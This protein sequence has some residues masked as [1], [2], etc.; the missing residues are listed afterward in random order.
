MNE[1]INNLKQP[2]RGY[3]ITST[4]LTFLLFFCACN[5]DQSCVY[6]NSSLKYLSVGQTSISNAG[7]KFRHGML[8]FDTHE[9]MEET[10]EN[11]DALWEA[12]EHEFMEANGHLNDDDLNELEIQSG[13]N[14]EEPYEIFEAQFPGFLSLRQDIESR[15]NAWL[16]DLEIYSSSEDPDNH[17]IIDDTYRAVLNTDAEYAIGDTIFKEYENTTLKIFGAGLDTLILAMDSIKASGMNVETLSTEEEVIVLGV[18]AVI[19]T[20][21]GG[22][23]PNS[24]GSSTNGLCHEDTRQ[25]DSDKEISADNQYMIKWKL[26][27]S[28]RQIHKTVTAVTKSYKKNR[29]GKWRKYRTSISARGFGHLTDPVGCAQ[30]AIDCGSTTQRAKKV[31]NKCGEGLATA[32]PGAI[33]GLHTGRGITVN[34]EINW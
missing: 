18:K 17:F 33:K 15:E 19:W 9:I 1:K 10:M 14:S 8:V 22:W 2:E 30:I 28:N 20:T 3:I 34:S 12:Q 13:Y 5:D 27:L 24:G 29:R 7:I 23:F 6:Q 32:R 21:Q 4:L 26:R 31:K 11:L 16:E 25:K